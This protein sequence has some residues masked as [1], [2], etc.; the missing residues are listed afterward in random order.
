MKCKLELEI[1]IAQLDLLLAQLSAGPSQNETD[2]GKGPISSEL[3]R[4]GSMAEANLGENGYVG[5][6]KRIKHYSNLHRILLVGE[7]DFS[8]AAC[9]ARKFGA[10]DNMVATSLDSRGTCAKS[11]AG[12][13]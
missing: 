11:H 2:K 9:L 3:I 7:G 6:E 13:R 5:P 12:A 1:Q 8:F 10:A 4:F